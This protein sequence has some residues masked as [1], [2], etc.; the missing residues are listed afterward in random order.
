[1]SLAASRWFSMFSPFRASIQDRR[2]IAEGLMMYETDH[3]TRPVTFR[4]YAEEGKAQYSL[5]R[6]ETA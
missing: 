2:W 6:S 5:T 1:M 4:F 3:A